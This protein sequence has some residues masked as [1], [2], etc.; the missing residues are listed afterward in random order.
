MQEESRAE[1][2]MR[3]VQGRAENREQK[4]EERREKIIMKKKLQGC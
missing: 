1:Q 2:K 3:A 4:G